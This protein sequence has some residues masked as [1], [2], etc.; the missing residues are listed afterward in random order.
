MAFKRSWAHVKRAAEPTTFQGK[1]SLKRVAGLSDIGKECFVIPLD[2]ENGYSCL[3]YHTLKK[4]DSEGFHG[5]SFN[6]VKIKCKRYDSETGEVSKELPLCCK[7]AQLE[8]D[9]KPEQEDSAQRALNFANFRYVFP[10]L[11]LS[12]T[13]DDPRKKPSLKK[14]SLNGIGFSFL[15]LAES[16]YEEELKN[17]IIEDLVQNDIIE[18][19]ENMDQ[20]ELM[21]QV[22]NYISHSIIK[23]S[24]VAAKSPAIPYQKAFRV[25]PVTNNLIGQLS[26]E[27]G[28]IRVLCKLLAGEYA[29]AQFDKVYAKYPELR[30]IN[31]QV[32]DY[33]Q[34][35]NDNID[36]LVEDY[37]DEELQ[38]YYDAYVAKQDQIEK[39]KKVNE[40]ARAHEEDEEVSFRTNSTDDEED[41]DLGFAEATPAPKKAATPVKATKAPVVEEEFSDDIDEIDDTIEDDEDFLGEDDVEGPARKPAP[42]KVAVA[43]GSVSEDDFDMGD[44]D[45]DSGLDNLDILSEDEFDMDED[46]N[47]EDDLD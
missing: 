37:T 5:S 41:I 40:E 25:I 4:N 42:K 44:L 19:P 43:A 8:K 23:V 46:G 12:T 15:D 13:E 45:S 16:S 30:E 21:Q 27:A 7:L 26:G 22:A 17:K 10:V 1:Y 34:L 28:A 9:R 14:L 32:I 11:V 35:Y 38:E 2:M 31:N 18:D 39:Y 47:F 24:N 36:S 3:P 29:P 6:S 33:L 20:E